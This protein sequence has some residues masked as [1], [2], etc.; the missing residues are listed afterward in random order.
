ML[1]KQYGTHLLKIFAFSGLL[2]FMLNVKGVNLK[3][4]IESFLPLEGRQKII[5]LSKTM[6]IIDDSYNANYES[7]I[8]AIN[9]INT[10]Q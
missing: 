5:N 4:T 2:A 7:M 6:R 3:K 1:K 8:T 10:F 9:Y